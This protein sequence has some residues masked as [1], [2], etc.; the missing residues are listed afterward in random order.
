MRLMDDPAEAGA[1]IG[2][3]LRSRLAL[4]R[5]MPGMF[6]QVLADWA[7]ACDGADV[8]VHNGQILA[9]QHV[10]EALGVPAVL[11]LPSPLYVPTARSRGRVR[12]CRRGRLK[13]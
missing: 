5:T 3:G 13:R 2:G 4:A 11:A 6:S 1:V 10:A 7:V 9:A 12:R 8:V